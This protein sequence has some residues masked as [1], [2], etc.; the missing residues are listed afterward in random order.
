MND[1]ASGV[2]IPTVRF[3][4]LIPLRHRAFKGDAREPGAVKE[5]I[6]T[7]ACYTVRNR[8]ARQSLTVSERIR[9][10]MFHTSISWDDAVSTS[11]NQRF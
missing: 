9:I 6:L 11:N 8:D 10:N 1:V 4:N 3:S 2:I 5:C 7:D